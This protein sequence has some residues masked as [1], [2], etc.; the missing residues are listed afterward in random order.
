[1]SSREYY[2]YILT[3]RSGTLY[4]GVTNDLHRR[5]LEHRTGKH[6]FTAKYRIGKLVYAESCPD[7]YSAIAREKQIKGWSRERKL[8]LT[9]TPNPAFRDL[10]PELGIARPFLF[11]GRGR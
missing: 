2:V 4:T 8:A 10:A 6:G 9:R 11:A 1:M 3:N 7:A 5:L